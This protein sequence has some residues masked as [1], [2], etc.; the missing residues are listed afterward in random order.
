[1]TPPDPRREALFAITCWLTQKQFPNRLLSDTPQRPFVTDLVYTTLRRHNTLEWVLRPLVKHLPHGETHAA[2]L[3]GAAQLLY[4]PAIPPYAAINET[5][6]AIKKTSRRAAPFVNAVLQALN[7]TPPNLQNAPLHIRHSHPKAPLDRWITAHGQPAAEALCAW[8]NQPAQTILRLLPNPGGTLPP[9][10]PGTHPHPADPIHSHIIPR[11]IRIET[12]QGYSEGHFVIQDPA[13]RAAI[14]L[15]QLQPHHTVL[16]AC[17]APGGKTA[18]IAAR[19]TTG[20]LTAA[21]LHPDRLQ[22]LRDTLT[23]TRHI[24]RTT[25]IQLDA[26]HP[27]S[28]ADPTYDRILLDAPCTNTG[29]LQRRPDARWR[30]TPAHL[31]RCTATQA[32][33]LH[34]TTLRLKPGG[35]LVYSTCSLEPEENQHQIQT[36]L[37]TH[38]HFEPGPAI[39]YTPPTHQTDGAYAATLIKRKNP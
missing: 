33:L 24:H 26:T 3:L 16:D 14:D 21:D 25:L 17:A 28:P 34:A 15:L 10:P 30:L 22:T 4:I 20:T 13:T 12:L 23:R 11:G 32:A 2:L 19:L 1:M 7:R 37:Q 18:Q 6:E 31:A 9:P 29:V 39:Q 5:V 27:P 35:I 38:P 36:F 8:N